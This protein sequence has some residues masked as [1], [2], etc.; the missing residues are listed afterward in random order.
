MLMLTACATAPTFL[1][2]MYDSADPCQQWQDK[3]KPLG[4]QTPSWCGAGT[5][6]NGQVTRDYYTGRYIYRTK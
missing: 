1:A 3:T 2:K 5:G 6:T 4:L